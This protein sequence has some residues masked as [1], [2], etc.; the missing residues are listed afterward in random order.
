MKGKRKENIYVLQVVRSSD[1]VFVCQLH[2]EFRRNQCEKLL[3]RFLRLASCASNAHNRW[4]ISSLE[5]YK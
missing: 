4:L 1:N 2:K 3:V 5:L